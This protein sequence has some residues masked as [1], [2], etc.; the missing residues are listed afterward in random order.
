MNKMQQQDE[1]QMQQSNF[2]QWIAGGSV[3]LIA[4]ISLGYATTTAG[5]VSTV[6]TQ[7]SIHESEINLLKQSACVQNENIENLASAVH[8]SYVSDPNCS[9]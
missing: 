6:S 3:G 7:V 2:L 9:K 1:Q 4:V 8:A 5:N